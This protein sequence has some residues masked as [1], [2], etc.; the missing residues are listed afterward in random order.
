[1]ASDLR[2]KTQ[3]AI[4]A[5]REANKNCSLA[6]LIDGDT[7][8]VLCKSSQSVIPQDELDELAASTQTQRGNLIASA[9]VDM[10]SKARS[11]SWSQF[12][13]TAVT[14]VVS[15]VGANQDTL[16][17]RFDSAPDRSA[18]FESAQTIFDLTSDA[19]AA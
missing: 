6:M 15:S 8:L 11:M 16:V 19:E 3:N 1:M 13:K 2:V 14:T 17:C 10:S 4:D 12:D 18:L 9:M 5:L 7:G